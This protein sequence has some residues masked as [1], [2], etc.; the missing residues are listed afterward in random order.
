MPKTVAIVDDEKDILEVVSSALKADGYKTKTFRDGRE[1]LLSTASFKP[2]IVLLDIMLPEVDGVEVCKQMKSSSRTA[3][4]PVIMIT[5]KAEET[6]VVLGLGVGADD[7][8][9][10]PFS[11]R[12]LIA[13]V[14]TVLRRGKHSGGENEDVIETGN[15]R[16]DG[17]S[18]V[19][20]V[21]EKPLDLTATQFR[22]LQFLGRN[23][24]RV[25]SRDQILKQKTAMDDR[26]AY[27][28]T[29]DVH[30]KRIREKISGSGV[31]IKTVRGVGYKLERT[32]AAK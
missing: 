23:E 4:I 27:D 22:I 21:K 9:T 14:K 30:I 1:F 25:L 28:R 2:D 15:L 3:D 11:P 16:I 24:G 10:K 13:R 31:E 19:A 5:A 20:K 8:I 18:F 29:V 12:E 7:Y 17:G 26:L 32:G 6:D